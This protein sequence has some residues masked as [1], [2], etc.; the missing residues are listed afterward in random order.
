MS[1][2]VRS[3]IRESAAANART[4][5]ERAAAQAASTQAARARL[6]PLEDRLARVL[7]TIQREVQA[8]GL[9][10]STIQTSLRGRWRGNAHPG[11]LG[12][13]LRNLGLSD[14]ADGM[15]FQAFARCGPREA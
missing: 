10:L 5:E 11:E 4:E 3:L 2:Y 1:A 9:S 13:A 15:T 12:A 14:N 8:E 7:K 6:M